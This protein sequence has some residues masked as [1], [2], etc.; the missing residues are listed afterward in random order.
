MTERKG[1]DLNGDFAGEYEPLLN[2][3]DNFGSDNFDELIKSNKGNTASK[4]TS[5]GKRGRP[6]EI[7][8]P[9]YKVV[10][11]TKISPATDTKLYNLKGY[12]KEFRE[13]TGRIS[14]DKIVDALAENYIKTQ[15]PATTEKILREQIKE[16]FDNLKK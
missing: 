15:L 9:R 6:V 5:S 3:A 12:M 7:K 2:G 16:D 10:V 4:K 14:F 8:D 13:S 11:P 1:F